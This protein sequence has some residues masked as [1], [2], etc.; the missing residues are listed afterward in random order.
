MIHNQKSDNMFSQKSGSGGTEETISSEE[1]ILSEN[2]TNESQRE[3]LQVMLIG[4]RKV[5]TSTIHY[6]HSMGHVEVDEWTPLEPCPSNPE[7]VISILERKV[8]VH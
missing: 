5:L 4:S 7:K 1:K 8:K 2:L 6:L 3:S